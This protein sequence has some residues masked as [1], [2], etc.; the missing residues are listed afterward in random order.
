MPSRS[1][2]TLPA[3]PTALFIDKWV[4]TPDRDAGSVRLQALIEIVGGLGLHV[5]FAP[6]SRVLREP[7]ASDLARRGVALAQGPTGI[8]G[9]VDRVGGDL[10]VAFLSRPPVARAYL[11]WLREVAPQAPVLYDTVD[12][13]WRREAGHATVRGSS[14]VARWAASLRAR[15]LDVMRG[16]DAT[17][18]VTDEEAEVVRAAVPDAAVFVIPLIHVLPVDAPD[19]PAGRHSLV[20]VGNFRHHPNIDAIGWFVEEVMPLVRADVPGVSLAIAGGHA[21]RHVRA[22]ASDD[23][24]VLGWLPDVRELYNSARVAVAP[25]RYGAG[26]KGKIGEA[27]SY[28][29][30]VVTT[31]VGAEGFGDT[32]AVSVARDP[33]AIAAHIRRLFEDDVGWTRA[34]SAGRAFVEA[35][36]SPDAARPKVR[37]MLGHLGIRIAER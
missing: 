11:P 35:H 9:L 8:E 10:V 20:F 36:L 13:A 23:I 34:S 18:V 1:P 37:D 26:M 29:V 17:I 3:G 24:A 31:P 28:G 27:L 21:P 19:S 33:T 12:L 2:E 4:P 30:P 16:V 6:A 25:L 5:A 7:Y 14:R 32:A 22:L 15:D